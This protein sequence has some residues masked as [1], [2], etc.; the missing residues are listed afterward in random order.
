MPA[1]DRVALL[2]AHASIPVWHE[3]YIPDLVEL[4]ML[5]ASLRPL[6]GEVDMPVHPNG[7]DPLGEFERYLERRRPGLVGISVFTSGVPAALRYAEL[8]KR[9]GSAVVVGGYHPSA[10]PEEL[11]A[12][13]VVDWVVR[14]EGELTLAALARAGSPDGVE[15]VSFRRNGAVV[16][17]PPRPP[18][19][20]LNALPAPWRDLRPER[21][22]R[23]GLDYHTDTIYAS[24]GCRGRCVFCANHLVGG[25]WRERNMEGILAELL[26]LPG[27]R[28]RRP[29]KIKFWDSSFLADAPRVE[30]L[31]RG[32]LEHGLQR[33]FR[34]IAESRA[35]DI[36]RAADIVPLMKE[37]GF[38]RIGCGIESPHRRTH[39]ALKKG[40][41][42]DHVPRAADLLTT[43]GIQ[44]SKFY[45]VGHEGEGEAD[46]LAYPEHALAVGTHRQ[47][48][49]FFIMTPYPGTELG[50]R[51]EE[52]GLIANRDWSLYNNL[53]AVV[54]PEG[55]PPR[56]LQ[57][58]HAGVALR[59]KA[60]RRFLD[61][62]PAG[63]SLGGLWEPL[64]LLSLVERRR[65]PGRTRRELAEDLHA[66]LV[67]ARGEASRPSRPDRRGG[68]ARRFALRFHLK[69]LPSVRIGG[70]DDGTTATMAIRP[71]PDAPP[72]P[73]RWEVH[74]D[75]QRLA[76]LADRLDHRLLSSDAL[77]LFWTP[78]AFRLRW[79]PSFLREA[80]KALAGLAGMA[81]FHCRTVLG[82]WSERG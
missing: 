13:P 39:A 10:R 32:I 16:H 61:G 6:V 23:R 64:F 73:G 55:I 65:D 21:C 18:I 71:G 40:L 38:V 79:A 3:Y 41:N 78:R 67:A 4:G 63:A 66:A 1:F 58:L 49:T 46:I 70:G 31:C 52:R 34:F 25:A 12:S 14:G 43:A 48:T 50:A 74:L 28:R 62:V 20:D 80:A 45:I 35:E 24:R 8:A 33:P 72:L 29:K 2:Q 75:L 59:H 27:P 37:A 44:F 30:R 60:F 54:S 51:Y 53:V 56:R 47:H 5:A 22:G 57:A 26:S 69:G 77:T 19:P 42:P 68:F 7:R 36:V 82:G 17:N 9:A 15:G 11:L 81:W 76:S